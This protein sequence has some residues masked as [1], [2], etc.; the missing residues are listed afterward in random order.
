MVASINYFFI[1]ILADEDKDGR[2]SFEEFVIA[3]H[4]IFIAKLDQPLPIHLQN[5]RLLPEEV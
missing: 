3:M 2:L 5:M 1:R 4:L